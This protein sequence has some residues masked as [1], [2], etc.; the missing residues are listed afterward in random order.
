[1][2]IYSRP[3]NKET[4]IT[5][6]LILGFGLFLAPLESRCD[7]GANKGYIESNNIPEIKKG[8][9]ISRESSSSGA[10]TGFSLPEERDLTAL[11]KQ[12]RK[13]RRQGLEY[14]RIG[15]ID[16]A[17]SFYQKAIELD[18]AYAVT[19]NDLGI[20]YE[21]K[22]MIER[23]IGA[24]LMAIKIDPSYLSAYT[25]LALIYENKRDLKQAA[26]YWEKRAQLGSYDDPWT[27]KARQRLK[28]IGLV[29]SNNPLEDA[30]EEE[31]YSFLKDVENQKSILRKDDS[32]LSNKHFDKAKQSYDRGDFATAIKEAVDAQQLN[33]ANREIEKFIEKVQLRA[34]SK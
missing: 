11:Q 29:L 25:N 23:A 20:T 12:A 17:M 3:N 8:G 9:V 19:Y 4:T 6:L 13:Y 32:A 16:E 24:Y 14:Q 26:F 1:M 31:V 27:E 18:P 30:R 15:N 21:S 22:G 5:I 2:Y 10:L 33:P 34:L 7:S 28:D